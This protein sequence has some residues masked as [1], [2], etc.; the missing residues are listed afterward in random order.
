MTLSSPLF[1]RRLS[2]SWCMFNARCVLF[3]M[4]NIGKYKIHT[5]TPLV[6]LFCT[7]MAKKRQNSCAPMTRHWTSNSHHRYTQIERDICIRSYIFSYTFFFSIAI[8][9]KRGRRSNARRWRLYKFHTFLSL[10][11]CFTRPFL[12]WMSITTAWDTE[13]GRWKCKLAWIGS[14]MEFCERIL[15]EN[16]IR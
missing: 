4:I 3:G 6:P 11:A 5:H 1:A 13:F 10:D 16:F 8:F 12:P 7:G 15:A 9:G 2:F 14:A